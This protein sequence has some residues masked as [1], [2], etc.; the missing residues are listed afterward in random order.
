M[1]FL[2]VN[3][4]I[5]ITLVEIEL[6]AATAPHNPIIRLCAMP[7]PTI[8]FYMGF[9]FCVS[10]ILTQMRQPLPFNMSSSEKGTPWKPALLAFIEDAGAIEGQGGV[11]YRS[12]VLKRY[13]V[14]SRFRHMILALTWGWGIMLLCVATVATILVMLLDENVAFGVGWGLPWAWCTGWAFISVSYVKCQ[15]KREKAEWAK[16]ETVGAATSTV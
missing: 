11:E 8:C 6:V 1:E 15:L 7:S 14:S 13:A 3:I 9:L 16:K 10:A 2:Q 12:Q 5:V 4:L